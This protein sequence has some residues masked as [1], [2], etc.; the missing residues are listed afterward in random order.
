MLRVALIL[1]GCLL[2]YLFYSQAIDMAE[3]KA[4]GI[5]VPVVDHTTVVNPDEGQLAFNPMTNSYWYYDGGQWFEL[6]PNSIIDADEDTSISVDDGGDN[7]EVMFRLNGKEYG[8]I[9]KNT[10]G[11]HVFSLFNNNI[12]RGNVVFGINSGLN[13]DLNGFCCN[14]LFGEESGR[15]LTSGDTNVM[16]GTGAGRHSTTASGNTFIGTDSGEANINGYGNVAVG[17]TAGFSNIGS[18]HNVALGV[19]SGYY[20][21]AADNTFVGGFSG[22]QTTTGEENTQYTPLN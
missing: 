17:K 16:M 7:D 13:L 5:V 2:P 11:I 19:E 9:I 18:S 14:S 1:T 8:R 10:N 15:D 3:I 20:N 4:D 6:S 12:Q 22:K 21:T